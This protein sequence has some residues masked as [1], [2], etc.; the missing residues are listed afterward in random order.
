MDELT[1]LIS[2]VGFPI[3]AFCA[4]FY[5]CNTTIKENTKA[6]LECT[7]AIKLF[8]NDNDGKEEKDNV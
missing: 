8:N 2:N 1:N 7:T 3:A 5:M 4:M 6:I